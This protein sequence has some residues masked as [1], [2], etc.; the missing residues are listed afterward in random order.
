MKSQIVWR[1][2]ALIAFVP[3]LVFLAWPREAYERYVTGPL[4]G[5]GVRAELL[6]PRGWVLRDPAESAPVRLVN[7]RPPDRPGWW[8]A[9]LR[10]WF[11]PEDPQRNFIEFSAESDLQ[12]T[13]GHVLDG[14]YPA[15]FLA[16]KTLEATWTT[17]TVEYARESRSKL[18]STKGI[19]FKGFKILPGG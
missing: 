5:T 11:P 19:I 3:A 16:S 6:I 7:F 12:S 15:F 18:E 1:L 14:E 13:V 17:A 2:A 10:R 9:F 8:P 4:D